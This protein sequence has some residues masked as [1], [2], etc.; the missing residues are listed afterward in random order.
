VLLWNVITEHKLRLAEG[1]LDV[2]LFDV[3]PGEMYFASLQRY[4]AAPHPDLPYRTAR[5]YGARLAGVVV[6]FAAEA[7]RAH[8]VLGR[9]AHVIPN[10]VPLGPC[11]APRLERGLLVIGTAARIHPDKR[12]ADLLA[13]LRLAAA[14]L[15]PYVLRIAGGVDTGAEQHAAE[16]REL[17]RGLNVE[18]RGELA[19]PRA[20]L[21]DLDLFTLVAEPEG[22]PNAS[23]EA[24]A[25]GLPII[26][27]AVGGML[28]QLDSPSSGWLVPPRDAPALANAIVELARAP[29]R[30]AC[31]GRAAWERARS[32]FSMDAMVQSY[33]LVCGV[34]DVGSLGPERHTDGRHAPDS[35]EDDARLPGASL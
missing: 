9:R 11:P 30:R 24:M 19:D 33:G 7:E 14:R 17:A 28:E 29:E 27:T 32:H 35:V 21:A 1:L 26:A 10:G 13:A 12:L 8:E 5:D 23:L 6:K 15:P 25:A 20:F 18:W 34:L 4:F 3:S 31:M 22:C 16:L 2:P